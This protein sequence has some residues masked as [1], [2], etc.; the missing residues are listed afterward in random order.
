MTIAHKE[1]ELLLVDKL[2]FLFPSTRRGAR[3][4]SRAT[5]V[6]LGDQE[7]VVAA[8]ERS[9]SSETAPDGVAN[10]ATGQTSSA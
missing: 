4:P 7:L 10:D 8:T 1:S 9:R 6:S 3:S 2:T 5:N